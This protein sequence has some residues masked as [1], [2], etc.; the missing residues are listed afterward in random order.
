MTDCSDYG[1]S[2]SEIV[3][4]DGTDYL[5]QGRVDD[6]LTM[7]RPVNDLLECERDTVQKMM[8]EEVLEE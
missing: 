1:G 5:V 8:G 3:E 4:V 7:F 6:H 2:Y